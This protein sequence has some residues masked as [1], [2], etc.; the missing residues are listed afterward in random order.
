MGAAESPPAN[1]FSLWPPS[2][3]KHHIILNT[4]LPLLARWPWESYLTSLSLNPITLNQDTRRPDLTWLRLKEIMMLGYHSASC[5]AQHSEVSE[6]AQSC[7][8]LFDSMDCSPPGFSIHGVFQAR[9]LEWVAISFSRGSSP[10]R[11]RTQV[12][13]TEGR[14]F[15]LSATREVPAINAYKCQFLSPPLHFPLFPH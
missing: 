12:S 14:C 3:P 7:P 13:C 11:D 15:T 8:T 10:P 2:A 6:V 9:I 1:I 4:A 5:L